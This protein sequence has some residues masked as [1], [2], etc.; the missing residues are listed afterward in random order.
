MSSPVTTAL[1]D[2]EELELLAHD[3]RL[4]ALADAFAA[5][6]RRRPGLRAGRRRRRSALLGG[7]LATCG[8]LVAMLAPRGSG[9]SFTERAAAAIGTGSVLHVVLVAAQPGDSLVNL[10]SGAHR[11]QTTEREYWLDAERGIEHALVR[12]GG[13]LTEDRLVNSGGAMVVAPSAA[14][15]PALEAFVRGYREALS[16]GRARSIGGGMVR[17]VRVEWLEFRTAG[18]SRERVG[19]NRSTFR[20]VVVRSLDATGRGVGWR[21]GDIR[22]VPLARADLSLPEPRPAAP[23]LGG[24]ADTR[25]LA[26]APAAALEGASTLWAGRG[27]RALRLVSVKLDTLRTAYPAG[28]G[29]RSQTSQG[30]RLL[31]APPQSHEPYVEVAEARRPELA[32][33]FSG[34]RETF[35]GNPIPAGD[36]VDVVSLGRETIGQLRVG[37]T[38]VTL[39]ASTEALLLAAARRLRPMPR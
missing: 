14:V 19:V 36:L 30:V 3:P 28:S 31:Y 34:G 37:S 2:P 6:Q 38:Y 29:R 20:P 39:R 10:V 35:D 9:P 18:G 24:I 7:A 33:S 4:L 27:F 22:L 17:G 26:T 8:L 1:T 5:T 25:P 12:R 16:S 21:V 15:H 11:A 32:Y 23:S 13:A